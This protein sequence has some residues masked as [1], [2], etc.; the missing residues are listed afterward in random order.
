[1]KFK[2]NNEFLSRAMQAV[3]I[4]A[5]ISALPQENYMASVW[6]ILVI[7]MAQ[8][9]IYQT[10]GAVMLRE[11]IDLLHRHKCNPKYNLPVPSEL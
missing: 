5:L 11:H 9:S 1:M 3:S 8:G 2:V 7:I 6:I 10:R 4:L